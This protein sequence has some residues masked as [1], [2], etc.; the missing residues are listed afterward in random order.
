M[1]H[2][3]TVPFPIPVPR[4]VQHR[5]R[6]AVQAAR[7]RGMGWLDMEERS[8]VGSKTLMKFLAGKRA[9][10]SVPAAARVCKMLGLK[11]TVALVDES[12]AQP[13][14]KGKPKPAPAA[15]TG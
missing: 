6:L 8:L 1:P 13:D 14:K 3:S 15:P 10:L 12:P 9:T 5:I 7:D 11:L 4:D 2:A